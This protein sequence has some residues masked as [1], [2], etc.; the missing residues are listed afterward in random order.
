[1]IAGFKIVAN[2][3]LYPYPANHTQP[4]FSVANMVV[5]EKAK[6]KLSRLM[7][8]PTISCAPSEGSDQPGCPPSLIRGFAVCM[9]K[10]WVISY[11]LSTPRRLIRLGGCPGWSESSLG[12]QIILLVLSCGGSIVSVVFAVLFWQWLIILIIL[13]VDRFLPLS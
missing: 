11:P 9:K 1:M 10:H 5:P 7:T 12:A 2:L 6:W 8:K 3:Q 13:V 4:R